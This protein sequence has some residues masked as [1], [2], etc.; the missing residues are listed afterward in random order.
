M[1]TTNHTRKRDGLG[2]VDI[3]VTSLEWNGHFVRVNTLGSNQR[4][5]THCNPQEIP[6]MGP[7][8][9]ACDLGI[10]RYTIFTDVGTI[11]PLRS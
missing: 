11:E 6:M 2:I 8:W 7:V 10:G 9:R 5:L 1:R 3:N 4:S